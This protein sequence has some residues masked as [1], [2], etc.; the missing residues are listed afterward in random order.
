MLF[1]RIATRDVLVDD[2]MNFAGIDAL[3]AVVMKGSAAI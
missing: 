3:I 2:C 1:I